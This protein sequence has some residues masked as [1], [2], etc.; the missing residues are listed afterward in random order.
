MADDEWRRAERAWKKA[1]D[2]PEAVERALAAARRARV[3]VPYDLFERETRPATTFESKLPFVVLAEAGPE[4]P[5]EVGQTPGKVEVPACRTWWVRPK[6]AKVTAKVV[7]ELKREGA[8]GLSLE[9]AKVDAAGLKLL[10]PLGDQ[11]HGLSLKTCT[12]LDPEA[13]KALDALP[14]LEALDLSGAGGVARAALE[15]V[16]GL[17]GLVRLGLDRQKELKAPDLEPLVGLRSLAALSLVYCKKIGKD[18]P[19]VL[20]RVPSLVDLDLSSCDQVKDD[21]V[22]ALAHGCPELRRLS[23]ASCEN[24]QDGA[25]AALGELKRLRDLNLHLCRGVTAAGVGALAR[26][27]LERLNLEGICT[28][29]LAGALRP[30]AATLREL[31]GGGVSN[32]TDRLDAAGVEALGDL[33]RLESLGLS[34]QSLKDAALK[35]LAKLERLSVLSLSL[36]DLE[37]AGLVALSGLP[38]RALNLLGMHALRTVPSL[39]ATLEQ[40]AF[41]AGHAFVADDLLAAVA[42]CAGLRRLTVTSARGLTAKGIARLPRSLEALDLSHGVTDDA[43]LAAVVELPALEELNVSMSPK[44]TP[45]GAAALVRASA[46]RRLTIAAYLV[47]GATRDALEERGCELDLIPGH[48]SGQG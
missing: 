29:A 40:L 8:P 21:G 19:H 9:R 45:A 28:S 46:L 4:E 41:S 36:N 6:P 22:V 12:K 13:L 35:P 2:E 17:Q 48:W 38:L 24:V 11:L 44:L 23:V 3:A 43:A 25:L 31:R 7:D 33:R 30:A 27:P 16:A 42:R 18:A 1:P 47:E 37:G 39:P 26:A 14:G 20:A 5:V 15:T 32:Q 34:Q 10:A